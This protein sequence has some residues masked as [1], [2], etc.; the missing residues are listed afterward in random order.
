ME[1]EEFTTT[2]REDELAAQAAATKT[3]AVRSFTRRRPVRKP[4]P[5]D[6]ERQRVVIEAPTSCA[7]CGGSRLAKLGEDVTE[8]LEE[9][10][11]GSS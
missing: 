8:L 10:R 3:Q 6:I 5:D 4:W 1:F 2:A 7:C 9:I 11:G